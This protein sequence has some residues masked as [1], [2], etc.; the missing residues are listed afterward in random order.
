MKIE[1]ERI[2]VPNITDIKGN[3]GCDKNNLENR[4]R[5]I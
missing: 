3:K 4:Y 5:N 2:G 1:W